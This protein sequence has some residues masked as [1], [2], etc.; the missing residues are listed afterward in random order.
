MLSKTLEELN[1]TNAI[2]AVFVHAEH[3]VN[4]VASAARIPSWGNTN[5]IYLPT[6]SMVSGT[7]QSKISPKFTRGTNDFY[8]WRVTGR[9]VRDS[10]AL[11]LKSLYPALT[12]VLHGHTDGNTLLITFPSL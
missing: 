9:R 8:E 10:K 6:F 5:S 7:N 11:R 4:G 12:M 2:I 3:C 1:F